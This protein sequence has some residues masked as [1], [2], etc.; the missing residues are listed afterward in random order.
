[1]PIPDSWNQVP[2]TGA[3]VRQDGS[4]P[5]GYVVFETMQQGIVIEGILYSPGTI[6]VKLVNGAIPDGF[7]LPSTD[8]V[9]LNITGWTYKVTEQFLGGREPFNIFIPHDSTGEDLN[10]IV[11][12]A[13]P[14]E[15]Q[16][17]LSAAV[18][19]AAQGFA[20]RAENA[21]LAAE[22]SEQD[23]SN[24]AASEATATAAATTATGAASS[25][26]ASAL[27]AS[28]SASQAGAAATLAGTHAGTATTAAGAASTSAAAATSS[29][30]SVSAIATQFGDVGSAITAAEAARDTAQGHAITATASATAADTSADEAAAS[31]AAAAASIATGDI[32]PDT[33]TGLAATTTGQYFSVPGADAADYLILYRNNAGSA[34]EVKRYPSVAG[35]DRLATSSKNLFDPSAITTGFYYTS[36]GT[37]SLNAARRVSAKMPVT[38]GQQVSISGFNPDM[39]TLA[40]NQRMVNFWNGETHIGAVG[41]PSVDIG[42]DYMTEV[43][44]AGATSMSINLPATSLPLPPLLQV[45]MAAKPTIY[46]PYL[47]PTIALAA[48]EFDNLHFARSS[49]NLFDGKLV[50]NRGVTDTGYNNSSDIYRVATG[51]I[52]VEVGKTYTVSGLDRTLVPGASRV[53]GVGNPKSLSVP[54]TEFF[55][56]YTGS[57]F[58]FTVT[59]AATKFIATQ[60]SVHPS[61]YL[62]AFD[63][64]VQVEEGSVATAYEPYKRVRGIDESMK[65]LSASLRN[66]TDSRVNPL[67]PKQLTSFDQLSISGPGVTVM[68]PQR[69]FGPHGALYLVSAAPADDAVGVGL[70]ATVT[71]LKA[72]TRSVYANLCCRNAAGTSITPKVQVTPFDVPSGQLIY[73]GPSGGANYANISPTD[74]YVHPSIA[75]DA[76][77]VAG[78]KYWMISSILPGYSTGGALWE[79]E[80]IFVSNDAKN[81]LRIRSPYEAARPDTAPGLVLPPHDLVLSGGRRYGFLPCPAAGDTVE[82][83]VPADNGGAALN[84]VNITLTGLPWKHDPAILIDGGYVYIYHSYHLVYADRTGGKNRFVVC[85]RTN[86]GVNWECVRSDGSTLPLDTASAARQ[87]F[88]KDG[89]G[90]YNYLFYRYNVG[91]SNPGVI[92]YGTGDYE[93]V[94]GE[95][96]SER[97]KGTTPW[98]FD[99]TTSFPFQSNG[100]GNHPGLL[101]SGGTLYLLNQNGL[102][103]SSNRGESFTQ[104]P[105]Y[106]I[107]RG[108]VGG[109]SYKK[110]MCVGAGGKVIALDTASQRLSSSAV[111]DNQYAQTQRR[112][113]MLIQE[114]PSVAAFTGFA[115]N[116]LGDGYIDLQIDQLNDAAGTRKT[117]FHPYR[118]NTSTTSGVNNPHQRVKLTDITI[119]EGDTLYLYISLVARAG[120]S[121]SFNGLE[122]N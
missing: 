98:N 27:A 63:L 30:A 86:D 73:E 117:H 29:A 49:K 52:P 2:V 105:F 96:F 24:A 37:K 91:K 48:A 31:A 103:Q 70:Y 66:Y 20:V 109:T 95:N 54:A 22:G 92:K 79:D 83:S 116:G 118:G 59:N 26:T 102:F 36:T 120:G 42:M 121:V 3:Y 99:F 81:W 97:F 8:D 68:P 21:A 47:R 28:T 38:A 7:T 80:D 5:Q 53:I 61:R 4:F 100:S 41:F 78:Y 15:M 93:F 76:T 17:A 58:T 75:Y 110:A 45:E 12:V 19:A 111:V 114:F 25:A 55:G 82:I 115:A 87:M 32:Y 51:F 112:N 10:T 71:G 43:V 90:R 122:I 34:V 72:G 65:L 89:S 14:P 94:Y 35:I 39:W 16:S 9:D 69:F 56:Q 23:A 84:N 33:A 67:V 11:P 77:G 107:W 46:Q 104:L 74:D 85:T 106:P 119:A 113:K 6:R 40:P 88:T 1:M 57:T 44:P 18:I 50:T 101:L 60:L 62:E 64:R 13:P 108:G